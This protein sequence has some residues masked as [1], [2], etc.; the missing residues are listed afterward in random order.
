MK[1][2]PNISFKSAEDTKEFEFLNLTNF[3]ARIPTILDHNPTLPHRI[4]F[5]ALLIITKGTGT[6]LIDLKKYNLEEGSVLKISKG[7]IHAFQKNA[8][9]EGFLIVF[10][11]KFILKY[12]SKSSIN[13]ISHLYNYHITSPIDNQKTLNETFLN[14]LII[15][16]KSENTYAQKNIV[17]ALFNLYLLRLER[18][19][20]PNKLQK[21]NSK[22]YNIFMQFKNLVESNYTST[23]NVK[24]YA[25]MLFISTKVLNQVVKDFTLNTAKSFID[26]YVILEIKRSIISTEKSLKEI[27]F[28]I[29]FDEVTNFTKF[30]KNKT[31]F[32]PKEFINKQL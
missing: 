30:F 1:N 32:P 19:S 9:Y 3:F 4:S 17:A 14:S 12:F 31:G 8:S 27:A 20:N 28:D 6:H 29:G 22:Q 7:Q 16:F 24:D 5:F 21:S 18:F 23:R 25:S 13:I 11:E 26:E 2:V 10:S 15:E